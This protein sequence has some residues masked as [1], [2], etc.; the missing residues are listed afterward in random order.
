VDA[1]VQ[2]GISAGS[3]GVNSFYLAIGDYYRVPEREIVVV[4]E[5]RIPDEEIPVVFFIASRAHVGSAAVMD[6][7]LAGNSWMDVAL[8]FGLGPDVFYVPVERD[9]GPPYGH[10]YGYYK[11]HKRKQWSSIRLGDGDIVNFVNLRFMSEHY[12]Y[13]PDQVIRLRSEGRSFRDINEG[14]HKQKFEKR[15]GFKKE[16]EWGREKGGPGS[17]DKGH[18]DHGRGKGN[19]HGEDKD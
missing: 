4:R 17:K 8:H 16:K 1:Q 10:A 5:R 14:F 18:G 3:G 19:K 15:E 7:R 11:H 9:Y 13:S 12:G 6:F 2:F